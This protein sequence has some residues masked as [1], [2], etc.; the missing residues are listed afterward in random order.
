MQWNPPPPNFQLVKEGSRQ[1]SRVIRQRQEVKLL[2]APSWE[3]CHQPQ[4]YSLMSKN[5]SIPPSPTNTE[6]VCARAHALWEAPCQALKR[7][8]H[9]P[10]PIPVGLRIWW[11]S[12]DVS[13]RA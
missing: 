3:G 2:Q 8:P 10:I 1:V 4:V 13:P 9:S 5:A 12:S 6:R 7:V 11:E